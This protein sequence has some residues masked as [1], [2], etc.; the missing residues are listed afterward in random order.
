MT[1]NM[2]DFHMHEI[3]IDGRLVHKNKG[4]GLTFA[5]TTTTTTTTSYES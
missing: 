3:E 1:W 4:G 5:T 2:K